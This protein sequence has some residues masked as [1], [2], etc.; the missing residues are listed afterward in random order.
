MA[1]VVGRPFQIKTPGLRGALASVQSGLAQNTMDARRIAGDQVVQRLR[2]EADRSFMNR[3]TGTMRR[4]YFFKATQNQIEIHNKARSG[5]RK[6]GTGGGFPYPIVIEKRFKAAE[7][8]I[9]K[10]KG[11]IVEYSNL[12]LADKGKARQG[13]RTEL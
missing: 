12:I 3:D 9:L 4:N 6:R 2:G 13:Y 1:P 5:A 8:T 7:R 10:H 11:R